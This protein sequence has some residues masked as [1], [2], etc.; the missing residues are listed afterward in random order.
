MQIIENKVKILETLIFSSFHRSCEGRIILIR[1][2]D[3]KKWC[4]LGSASLLFKSHIFKN[5]IL[6]CNDLKIG[7]WNVPG[8]SEES[9]TE[10][11][12][13]HL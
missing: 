10:E 9:W 11:G 2:R 12:V 6:S 3:R 13:D 5:I 4:G 7:G 1:L 8:S